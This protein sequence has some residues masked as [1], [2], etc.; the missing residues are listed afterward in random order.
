MIFSKQARVAMVCLALMPGLAQ[1]CG[2]GGMH[3]TV[4]LYPYMNSY[5]LDVNSRMAVVSGEIRALPP[6]AGT[7]GLAR[8]SGWLDRMRAT[9]ESNGMKTRLAVYL[10]DSRLWTRFEGSDQGVL[11]RSHQEAQPGDAVL[12][13]SEATLSA[14]LAQQISFPQAR[15]ADLLTFT[16]QPADTVD[17]AF[18]SGLPLL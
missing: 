6:L 1:A 16:G 15:D 4:T 14:L 11:M 9:L 7:E 18:N 8:A 2:Y 10:V 17:L 13:L 3:G 5:R 12:M